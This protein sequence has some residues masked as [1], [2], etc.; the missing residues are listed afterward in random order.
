MYTTTPGMPC[1]KLS[2]TLRNI[3]GAEVIPNRSLLYL[4]KPLDVLITT[5][6]LLGSSYNDGW[7]AWRTSNVLNAL[8]PASDIKRSS[9]LGVGY[10]SILV[11]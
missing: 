11:A 8:P 5:I 4:N 9:I 10:L 1:N 7:Y 3:P 2:M 6:F